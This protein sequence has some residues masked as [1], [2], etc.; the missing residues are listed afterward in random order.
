[1]EAIHRVLAY[2]SVA[3]VGVGILWSIALAMRPARDHRRFDRFGLIVSGLLVIAAAAGA[4]QL[5]TGAGPREDLHL[6]YAVVAIGLIPL[7]RSF[8]VGT[9]RREGLVITAAYLAL[10][11]LLFRLFTT[12]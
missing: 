1:M 6:L 10:G 11:G 12:A 5:A 4:A 2:V 7:A 8:V 3:A 9:S